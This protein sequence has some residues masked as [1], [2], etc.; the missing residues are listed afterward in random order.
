MTFAKNGLLIIE[1]SNNRMINLL[2]NNQI[3]YF[4]KNNSLNAL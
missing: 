3:F 4:W 1:Y 2:E